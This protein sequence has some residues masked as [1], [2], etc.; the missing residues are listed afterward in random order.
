MSEYRFETFGTLELPTD[1]E[2]VLLDKDNAILAYSQG[3]MEDGRAYWAYIAVIPSRYR[4][5]RTLTAA[6]TSLQ[7]RDYGEIIDAGYGE[8][9]PES[10]HE[11]MRREYGFNPAFKQ[12]IIDDITAQQRAFV[13]AREDQ[14]IDD[15][16]AML[17]KREP[18]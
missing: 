2:L 17:K 6:R 12:H 16:V 3:I 15:I 5:F 7:L 10:V 14:R 4:E 1:Q 13:Q 18:K 9:A 11:T 8:D